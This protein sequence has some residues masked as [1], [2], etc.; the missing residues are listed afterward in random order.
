MEAGPPELNM[1]LAE[2]MLAQDHMKIILVSKDISR[3]TAERLGFMYAEDLEQ[4][5]T[6]GQKIFPSAEVLVIPSGGVI[7]PVF[8]T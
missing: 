1:S 7:L 8:N 2:A 4:A 6:M 5:L 3:D